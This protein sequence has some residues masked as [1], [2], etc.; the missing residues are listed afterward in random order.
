MHR[1]WSP[2]GILAGTVAVGVLAGTLLYLD[3]PVLSA[4][5]DYEVDGY[6]FV[7]VIGIT[8]E[9]APDGV[10]VSWM[11]EFGGR[12]GGDMDLVAYT[13]CGPQVLSPWNDPAASSEP[14]AVAV[15]EGYLGTW[16]D[17]CTVDEV[18]DRYFYALELRD[19]E[20]GATGLN[21]VYTGTAP[22]P[23]WS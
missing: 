13:E 8:S 23:R 2:T 11:A 14:K 17:S 22:A 21:V 12:T 3:R 5:G 10:E 9:A 19:A 20:T 6:G 7:Q 1:R 4:R 15:P 18:G 16:Q